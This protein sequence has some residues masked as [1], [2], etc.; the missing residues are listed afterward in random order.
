[1]D[2]LI[3][4]GEFNSPEYIHQ[5]F[6]TPYQYLVSLIRMGEIQQPNLKRVQGMLIQLSMPVYMY[7]APIGYRNTQDAWLNPQAIL[8]RIALATAIANKRLNSDFPVKYSVVAKNIGELSPH[9]KKVIANSP[10]LRTALVFG[11][12]EAM[13]R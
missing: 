1:M 11:S 13:Y 5:K 8:Q 3:H 7:V 12:P 10:K 6:K 4:S 2:T 9:T